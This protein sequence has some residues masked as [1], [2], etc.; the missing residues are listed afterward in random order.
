MTLMGVLLVFLEL[1]ALGAIFAVIRWAIGRLCPEPFK[2]WV[3]VVWVVVCV[4]VAVFIL[5]GLVGVGPMV[6]FGFGRP[7]RP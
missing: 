5:L 3:D 4:F 2:T 1:V 7:L 6:G